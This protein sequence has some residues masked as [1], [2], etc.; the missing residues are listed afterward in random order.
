MRPTTWGRTT[1]TLIA[2]AVLVLVAAVVAVSALL[3]G[4]GSPDAAA[5][6]PTPAAATASPGVAPVDES[7]P[8]PTPD[9][10]A[11]VL[12]PALADPNLGKFTGRITDAIT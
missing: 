4:G 3:T 1:H 11:L 8:K 9:R 7:A 12:A 6:K 10:L 5:V 2:V